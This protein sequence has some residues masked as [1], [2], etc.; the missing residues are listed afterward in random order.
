MSASHD[1]FNRGL[2]RLLEVGT[3][4]ASIVIAVGLVLLPRT[5]VILT[6]IGLLISLP[7]LRVL[8]MFVTFLRRRDRWG[9]V[10]AALV[11]TIIALGALLGA[12]GQ[13]PTT[14]DRRLVSGSLR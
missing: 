9:I 14:L 3:W 7:V 6:G 13:S 11:L 12:T 5:G 4:L 1:S 10:I 2:A 8:V